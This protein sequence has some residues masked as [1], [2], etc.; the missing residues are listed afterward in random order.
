MLCLM[1]DRLLSVR[2]CM[3]TPGVVRVTLVGLVTDAALPK[4]WAVMETPTGAASVVSVFDFRRAVIA[5][6]LEPKLN[7]CMPQSKPGAFLCGPDQY[8]LL[9]RRAA[10]LNFLGVR[11][12]VFCSEPLALEWALEEATDRHTLNTGSALQHHRH[13]RANPDP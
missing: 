3:E 8:Q 9:V 12:A 11:R 13:V 7:F 10:Q 6:R 4:F 5:Y 1:P 2:Y